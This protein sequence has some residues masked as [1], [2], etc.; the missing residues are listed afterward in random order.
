MKKF[1][2]FLRFDRE[3]KWLEAMA[4]KG[5]ILTKKSILYTFQQAA[6]KKATVKIDYR[7]FQSKRDFAD[8][9]SLFEE[10]GW[11]HLAGTKS[12][13]TQYFLKS[14]KAG[15]DDIFSDTLS[16]AGMYKRYAQMWETWLIIFMPYTF[17]L[18]WNFS[19][20]LSPADWYFTPGLWELSGLAFWKAF[21]FETPFVIFRGIGGWLPLIGMSLCAVMAIKSDYMY[22][23][24]KAKYEKS[25][26]G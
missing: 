4:E 26:K 2:F 18:D 12:S 16:R 11:K 7:E 17:A 10:S 6:P 19:M 14:D 3:E 1:R 13:G 8:Y 5:W 25:G 20:L 22:R 15:G 21:L 9:C 24:E 23:S